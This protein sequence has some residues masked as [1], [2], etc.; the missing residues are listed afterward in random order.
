[1]VL[2][3]KNHLLSCI[4]SSVISTLFIKIH[5]IMHVNTIVSFLGWKILLWVKLNFTH[6]VV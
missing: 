6:L 4:F 5:K 1:M 3:Y 2:T